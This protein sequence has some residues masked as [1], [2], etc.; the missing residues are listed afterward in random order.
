MR[1]DSPLATLHAVQLAAK[2]LRVL[3]KQL[4]AAPNSLPGA[5]AAPRFN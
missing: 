1:R 5:I 2:A 3:L 4:D